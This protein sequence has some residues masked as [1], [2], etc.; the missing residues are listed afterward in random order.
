MKPHWVDTDERSTVLV[1]PRNLMLMVVRHARIVLDC[2]HHAEYEEWYLYFDEKPVDG[3]DHEAFTREDA[4][5]NLIAYARETLTATL[6][7]LEEI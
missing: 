5:A 7:E 2:P 4:K 1:G 6:A 3:I